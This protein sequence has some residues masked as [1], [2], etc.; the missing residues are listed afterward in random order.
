MENNI[1]DIKRVFIQNHKKIDFTFV[2]NKYDFIVEE[3]PNR[4]FSGSGN[5]LILKIK[6]EWLST[7]DL[8]SEISEA[9]GIDE[10]KIGYAGLK[11]KNATTTQ[12]ISIPLIKEK[13][14][15]EL[16][17]RNIQ[18]L[19]VTKDKMGLSIGDLVGN[20][21]TI[22]LKDVQ[23]ESLDEI[24]GVLAKI[25]K[26]G[27]PNYFGYQRF[28]QDYNFQKAQDV[29]YGEEIIKNKKLEHLLISAYQS[30]FFNAWLSKRVELAKKEG[31]NKLKPLV[32]DIFLN[33]DKVTI[34]GLLPG[35]KV[36]R[37]MGEAREIEKLYDD[38]F[39]H[40][41]GFRREAWIKVDDLKNKYDEKEEKLTLSFTL[42]KGSYATVLIENIANMNFKS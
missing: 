32:G 35:R 29:T 2:Q 19:E 41:K 14:L 18:I 5:Y 37:A 30:Y 6:K 31:L 23:K 25:Q 39:V 13:Y 15:K 10:H 26:H 33:N 9:F 3:I 24:Y 16:N 20:K 8:I 28:G 7:W 11:D 21:F 42:P 27:L 22:T 4:V 17:N 40:A 1:P 36:M 38:E 34:T 12:Y